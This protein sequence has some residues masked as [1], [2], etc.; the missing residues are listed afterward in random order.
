LKAYTIF[1]DILKVGFRKKPYY[2]YLVCVLVIHQC[3][4]CTKISLPVYNVH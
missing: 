3:L 4:M 2:K 1:D